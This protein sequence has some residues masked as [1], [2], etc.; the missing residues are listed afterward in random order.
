[1]LS[2]LFAFLCLAA[3][4][5]VATPAFAQSAPK[6]AVVDFQ[7]AV[8]QVKDGATARTNLEAMYKQK[9]TA[10]ESMEQQLMAMKAE[11]DKQALILSDTARQQKE[12]ELMV[13]QQNYQQAYMQHE[14]EMQTAYAN[15][16]EGLIEK[17]K[18]ICETIGKEKGYTLILEIN[19]G[20]VVYSTSSIDITAE[21]IKR[22]DAGAGN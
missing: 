7:E 15:A 5:M 14:Q 13:A 9:K 1:M 20:G 16:M 21:L 19:E 3:A 17:M 22:Y 18:T 8:N 6:I 4:L 2:R 10:I 12:R 11:Y